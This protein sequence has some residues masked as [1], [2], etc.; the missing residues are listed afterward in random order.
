MSASQWK[1]F[2]HLYLVCETI[3]RLHGMKHC[4]SSTQQ[5]STKYS[6][7]TE[8]INGNTTLFLCLRRV[9]TAFFFLFYFFSLFFR[10]RESPQIDELCVPVWPKY[11]MY[12]IVLYITGKLA[13][14]TQY[15]FVFM[16]VSLHYLLLSNCLLLC[17]R[18]CF[19][20]FYHRIPCSGS[21][22]VCMI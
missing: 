15:R 18:K 12:C 16:S 2:S 13:F 3:H 5:I 8:V 14:R 10:E 6:L 20:S 1:S 7:L 17:R 22:V 11:F 9:S 4:A 19:N 21:Y